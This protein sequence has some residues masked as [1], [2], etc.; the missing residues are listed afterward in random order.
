MQQ[1]AIDTMQARYFDEAQPW[2]SASPKPA[3]PASPMA[4]TRQLR[5]PLCAADE[6]HRRGARHPVRLGK[7]AA[8]RRVEETEHRL[9]INAALGLSILCVEISVFPLIRRRVLVPVLRNTRA[10][11]H[12]MQGKPTCSMA[13][14]SPPGATRSATWSAPWPPCATRCSAAA[15]W[16]RSATSL[17]EQLRE[18]SNTDFTGLPNHRAFAERAAALLGQAR[19]HDWFVAVLLFRIDDF[20]RI[21]RRVGQLLADWHCAW[22]LT[23]PAPRCEADL[24]A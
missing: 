4:S 21:H 12:V 3:W 17:V 20:H 22:R 15:T 8:E 7:E 10:M 13:G 6:V 5:R 24:L 14:R 16:S 19:R 9:W 23:S 2:S 11:V 1:A 18:A